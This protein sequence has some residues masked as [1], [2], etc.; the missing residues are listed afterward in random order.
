MTRK[1]LRF[2]VTN[3]DLLLLL[4]QADIDKGYYD[5]VAGKPYP[6]DTK[7]FAYWHGWMNG[8]TASG[9]RPIYQWQRDLYEDYITKA[10]A[11]NKVFRTTGRINSHEKI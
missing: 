8:S 6:D 1:V 2:P 7:S 9:H 11:L 5:A 10:N 4:P 3:Y